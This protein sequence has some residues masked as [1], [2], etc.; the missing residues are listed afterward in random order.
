MGLMPGDALQIFNYECWP[1]DMVRERFRVTPKILSQGRYITETLLVGPEQI[2]CFEVRELRVDACGCYE[3]DGRL[4]LAVATA[5][6]GRLSSGKDTLQ[7]GPGNRCL[8]A[9][10]AD[11]LKVEAE[12]DGCFRLLLCMPGRS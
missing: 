9:A 7:L 5:G 3:L 11:Q 12:T 6:K 8:I 4:T 1:L 10:A 2:D